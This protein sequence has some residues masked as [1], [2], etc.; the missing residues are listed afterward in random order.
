MWF[1]IWKKKRTDHIMAS[2]YLSVAY[3]NLRTIIIFHVFQ[4]FSFWAGKSLINHS[5]PMPISGIHLLIIGEYHLPNQ[6]FSEEL[7]LRRKSHN[8]DQDGK[9][10][11]TTTLPFKIKCLKLKRL[12][13]LILAKLWINWNIHSSMVECKVL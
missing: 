1:N 9:R 7:S 10:K 11:D 12:I 6:L 13:V 5:S 8:M 3:F 2:H 4:R